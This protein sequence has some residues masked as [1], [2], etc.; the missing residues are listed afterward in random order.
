MKSVGRVLG[1]LL[2]FVAVAAVAGGLAIG[3]VWVLTNPAK[4]PAE[5]LTVVEG[6]TE[7]AIPTVHT[8]G[9]SAGCVSYDPP[10]DAEGAPFPQAS[11]VP[12]A[13]TEYTL[14]GCVTIADAEAYV[15]TIFARDEED[16]WDYQNEANLRTERF[17]TC[18]WTMEW[19]NAHTVGDDDRMSTASTWLNDPANQVAH[20]ANDTGGVINLLNR[21]AQA[22]AVGDRVLVEEAKQRNCEP[23]MGLYLAY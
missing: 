21:G 19:L 9:P 12:S 6:T 22:A 18:A 14:P 4:G 8:L 2:A 16:L 3:A 13:A 10:K 20:A 11:E 17:A 15:A 5:V 23:E 7:A 1:A